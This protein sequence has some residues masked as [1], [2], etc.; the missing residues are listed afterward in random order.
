MNVADYMQ[1]EIGCNMKGWSVPGPENTRIE[2]L[3][4]WSNGERLF[5]VEVYEDGGFEVFAQI[6]GENK[7]DKTRDVIVALGDIDP[8]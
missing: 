7:L 1:E 3:E 6:I 2:R 8:V 4:V 5:I